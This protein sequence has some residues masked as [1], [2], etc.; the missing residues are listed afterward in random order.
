MEF[1][2]A[3][4]CALIT[5]LLS[6]GGTPTVGPPPTAPL[7]ISCTEL[8]EAEVA[9]TYTARLTADGGRA[10]Y[11][12][13]ITS[14][15]LPAG[16]VLEA[17]GQIVG[18]P[19]TP[20]TQSFTA[21]VTDSAEA[22]ATAELSIAVRGDALE[23]TTRSL[24][25][26]MIA[27][28]IDLAV[29]ARGGTGAGY[30]WSLDSGALPLGVEL[31][32]TGTPAT[33]LIGTPTE[34][35]DFEFTVGME[36]D[37]GARASVELTLTV[38]TPE[39]T[40]EDVTLPDFYVGEAAMVTVGVTGGLGGD[41]EWSIA[42]GA[43]PNGLTLVPGDREVTIAGVPERAGRAEFRLG[44]T[45]ANGVTAT[46]SFDAVVHEALRI[47]VD[48]FSA[49]ATVSVPYLAR[50]RGE[51]GAPGLLDFSVTSGALPDGL[52][53]APQLGRVEISGTPRA[54]GLFTFEITVAD[55]RG[56]TGSVM[57]AIDVAHPLTIDQTSLPGGVLDGA[58]STR[59]TASGGGST[60]VTWSVTSGAL[61]DGLAIVTTTGDIEGVP[62]ALGTFAFEVTA[63]AAG[64][65]TSRPFEITIYPP[66]AID[67]A[68]IP[69]RAA[70]ATGLTTLTSSGGSGTGKVWSVAAGA[71]PPGWVLTASGRLFGRSD[72]PGAHAF[73]LRVTDDV[74][75][76]DERDYSV[77]LTPSTLVPTYAILRHAPDEISRVN[78]CRTE[79]G[80]PTR[81]S[82]VG[83]TG[84]GWDAPVLSPDATKLA[85]SGNSGAYVVSVTAPSPTP[86]NLLTTPALTFDMVWSPDSNRLA[87]NTRPTGAL[88]HDLHVVD[89]LP[90][91]S[92]GPGAITFPSIGRVR[93]V[94]FSPDSSR[95]VF[96]LANAPPT[97]HFADLLSSPVTAQLAA[98]EVFLGP[99]VWTPDQTKLPFATLSTFRYV[100]FS[101]TP[102]S[103]STIDAGGRGR[104]WS[105]APAGAPRIVFQRSQG[106]MLDDALFV[107]DYVNGAFGSPTPLL[108]APNDS[109]ARFPMWNPQGTHV[110]FCGALEVSGR[111]DMYIVDARG[112]LPATPVRVSDPAHEAS[113]G[114]AAWSP[115]G[116]KLAFVAST[117]VAQ[118][119]WIA[120]ATQMV[121]P[122]PASP[123]PTGAFTDL[124]STLWSS[125]SQRIF[126]EGFFRG[127]EPEPLVA[128]VS[129]APPY[130]WH[131]L[132]P[133]VPTSG[134]RWRADPFHP[135]GQSVMFP[136]EIAGQ[137]GLYAVD[138]LPP[139]PTAPYRVLSGEASAPIFTR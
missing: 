113:C 82:P 134:F 39:L 129:G 56:G 100:D 130:S 9:V 61:P 79:P 110:A 65:T 46:R 25:S 37:F 8:A 123:I 52:S 75:A 47:E 54:R 7:T 64:D 53:L 81:L 104:S 124:V 107:A 99:I 41:V 132:L 131:L 84:A 133:S 58:Y 105:F 4:T 90:G 35:G 136:A 51:G 62:T 43:L 50:L 139:G 128:D 44:A 3:S 38:T 108:A 27:T 98:N 118:R 34:A 72:V 31:E 119:I 103:V 10:P 68:Q 45:D 135:D 93:D 48:V 114:R 111:D 106:S 91:G 121:P 97:L 109:P 122:A 115:D 14:G 20:E 19:T 89:V 59:L 67:T 29:E 138:F 87:Y 36:D 85:F 70:C 116:S 95:L 69:G 125:D 117:G 137:A 42:D 13:A 6:C 24:S 101:T 127:A 120:D 21:E 77:T 96:G 74:G 12:W 83:T 15:T 57:L 71:L 112:P 40:I 60:L 76:T 33:R 94:L 30:T 1:R 23:I 88:D 18:T 17:D 11:T 16:L 22:T 80:T 86:T 73:T 55:T 32:P 28:A 66:I 126:T 49:S 63:Q 26:V 92:P 2:L 78:V 102:P 5:L